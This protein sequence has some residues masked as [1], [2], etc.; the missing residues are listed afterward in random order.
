[1]FEELQALHALATTGSVT[2][3]ATQ[4]RI[5]QPA[6]SKRLRNLE[7]HL[8]R[9]LLERVGRGVVL[10][11][12]AEHL[13]K[14][15]APLLAELREILSASIAEQRGPI[16]MALTDSMMVSWGAEFLGLI[17]H[18]RSPI[19]ITPII[20]P[21]GNVVTH[22]VLSGEALV[23]V[24]RGTGERAHGVEAIELSDE[25]LCLVPSGLK[26]LKLTPGMKIDILCVDA[27]A[28]SHQIALRRLKRLMPAAGIQFRM[29]GYCRSGTSVIAAAKAGLGH[30]LISPR[31]ARV[32][33]VPPKV[34]CPLPAPGVSMPTTLV[35]RKRTL[36]LEHVKKLVHSLK[37]FFT[38]D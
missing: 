16:T 25:Q 12:Y 29:L 17:S 30:G 9:K 2:R 8:N 27:G 18:T 6:L 19:Q 7:T 28:E 23:G 37:E 14:E 36:E 3:A 21:A 1:M 5:S 4:L 31:L 24:I 26:P 35:A 32:M 13:C 10:T 22:H 15:T 33:G 20:L 38:G 34:L 11:T